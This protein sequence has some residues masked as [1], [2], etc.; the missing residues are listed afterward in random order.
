MTGR[1]EQRD[2]QGSWTEGEKRHRSCAFG[3]EGGCVCR[4]LCREGL[5]ESRHHRQ[6]HLLQPHVVQQLQEKRDPRHGRHGRW[7]VVM[8]RMNTINETHYRPVH[9]SHPGP[10]LPSNLQSLSP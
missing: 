3:E 8:N 7:I 9:L 10:P 6:Y 5:L 1:K 2:L 4:V